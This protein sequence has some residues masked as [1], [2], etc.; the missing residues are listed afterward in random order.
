MNAL[1]DENYRLPYIV[2]TRPFMD[3]AYL[4]IFVDENAPL[5]IETSERAISDASSRGNYSP[6]N[7]VRKSPSMS[8]DEKI[9]PVAIPVATNSGPPPPPPPIQNMNNAPPPPVNI[10]PIPKS[11]GGP[12]PPPPPIGNFKNFQESIYYSLISLRSSQP[13]ERKQSKSESP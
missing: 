5:N 12:P 8:I 4:G 2:G 13:S 3:D 10:A 1:K 7:L 9:V 11:K 6:T